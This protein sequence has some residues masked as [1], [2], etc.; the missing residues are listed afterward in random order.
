MKPRYKLSCGTL[1]L[2]CE[3]RSVLDE[4]QI[5][6][7]IQ[8]AYGSLAA[9]SRKYDLDYS[10]L[11]QALRRHSKKAAGK[12]SAMRRFL[13]LSS[14]PTLIGQKIVEAHARRRAAGLVPVARYSKAP[15]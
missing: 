12:V 6:E 13:G 4:S 2:L 9:F 8:H 7:R 5:Y 3:G 14:M 15:S 1:T 11:T 10:T